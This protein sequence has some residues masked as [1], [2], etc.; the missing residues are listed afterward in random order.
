MPASAVSAP[1]TRI[2]RRFRR[3][4][5]GSSAVEF[6]LVAAPFFALLFAIIE[7]GLVF[8]ASQVLEHGVQDSGR[9]VYT[10]QMTGT[11]TNLTDFKADLCPRVAGLFCRK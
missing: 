11:N 6:S 9:L 7:S 3:D 2:F 8:F 1:Q 5:S 10:N 4:Q